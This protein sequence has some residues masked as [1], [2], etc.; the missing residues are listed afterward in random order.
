[1]PSWT[2]VP[3]WAV[4]QLLTRTALDIAGTAIGELQTW[5][6]GADAD[7]IA[8]EADIATLETQVQ[9]TPFLLMRNTASVTVSNKVPY[10]TT[11]TDTHS[12]WSGAN[13]HY[14]IPATGYYFV[15]T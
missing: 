13:S 3:L 9:G 2:T 5:A 11:V 14:V 8:A 12:G 4:G 7:L 1:V 15:V 6:T 10:N